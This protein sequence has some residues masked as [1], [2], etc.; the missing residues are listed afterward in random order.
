MSSHE[1]NPASKHAFSA[2]RSAPGAFVLALTLTFGSEAQR[3]AFVELWRPLAEWVRANEPRTLSYEC[4]LADRDPCQVR[5]RSRRGSAEHALHCTASAKFSGAP[6]Y[7]AATE[8][9]ARQTHTH[10]PSQQDVSAHGG[11]WERVA[12]RRQ[13]RPRRV[14]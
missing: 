13:Q 11:C 4:A 10:A 9:C 7:R 3:G 1:P 5:R 6:L 14:A 2:A 12:G 8:L